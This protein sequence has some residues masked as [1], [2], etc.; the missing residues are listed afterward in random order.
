MIFNAWDE[1][2]LGNSSSFKI[3][4]NGKNI[5]I[6]NYSKDKFLL[7]PHFAIGKNPEKKLIGKGKEGIGLKKALVTLYS[8]DIKVEIKSGSNLY[9][10]VN[11]NKNKTDI[12]VLFAHVFTESEIIFPGTEIII[13]TNDEKVLS[14]VSKLFFDIKNETY[15]LFKNKVHI[16]KEQA[17]KVKRFSV[18]NLILGTDPNL[19]FSYNL[20]SKYKFNSKPKK[21]FQNKLNEEGIIEFI[22]ETFLELLNSKNQEELKL[23]SIILKPES[24]KTFN[25]ELNRKDI[26]EKVFD[27][28]Y[29]ENKDVIYCTS[30]E[31]EILECFK[32]AKSDKC[33]VLIHKKYES[34]F[35]DVGHNKYKIGKSLIFEHFSNR[36]NIKIDYEELNDL[37]KQIYKTIPCILS[38]IGLYNNDYNIELYEILLINDEFHLHNIDKNNRIIK[39]SRIYLKSVLELAKVI[40]YLGIKL[41]PI[42][43]SL[44]R[45][46]Y[47]T[48]V[49]NIVLQKRSLK[50]DCLK[51]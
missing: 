39:I 10:V 21:S 4:V 29:S 25:H 20:I 38:E 11:E 46:K 6:I 22:Q 31:L 41:S 12:P 43:E 48:E 42:D 15:Y 14:V 49:I 51:K 18:N 40:I 7:P 23:V 35:K 13:N 47:L 26:F 33:Y 5:K 50:N 37:E 1:V 19:F 27:K 32:I 24:L 2:Q 3:L 16:V 44:D 36:I 28:L 34:Y 45:D 9:K 8:M 30:R 17:E